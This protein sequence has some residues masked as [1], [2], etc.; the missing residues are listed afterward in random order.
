M[1]G[2]DLSPSLLCKH[3]LW[4]REICSAVLVGPGL[5]INSSSA[6]S[7]FSSVDRVGQSHVDYKN[8][9]HKEVTTDAEL[10]VFM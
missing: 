4:P 8:L 7:S 3:P 6:K 10:W 2:N 5:N 9:A 1:Y